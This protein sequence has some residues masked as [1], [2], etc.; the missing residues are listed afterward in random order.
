M[1]ARTQVFSFLGGGGLFDFGDY[2][3]K[4]MLQV[5]HNTAC[6]FMYI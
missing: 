1:Q 5:E 3:I 4:I 6:N 2:V